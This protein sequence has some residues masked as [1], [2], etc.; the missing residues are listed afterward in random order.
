MENNAYLSSGVNIDEGNRFVSLIKQEVNST[1]TDNTISSIGGFAGLFDITSFKEMENP[2]LVSSTDGVGTKLKIAIQSGKVDTVGIDL[3][4]MSVN[5]LIVL[6]ATPLFFLDYIATGSLASEQMAE[7]VK[8]IAS[9]CR[10]CNMAL[11]GGET[12]EMPGMY[13]VGDFDLAGFAVGIVD[14]SKIIDGST[15]K[16]GDILIGIS[17]SGFHSN[18]YS[19]VRKIVSEKGLDYKSIFYG[20]VTVAEALLI[21]TNLYVNIVKSVLEKVNVKGMVHITGGG[22]YDN[23][24]RV[25][26]DGLGAEL[27]ISSVKLPKPIEKLLKNVEIS[28]HELYRVFNMGVGFVFIVAKEDREAVFKKA[29]EFNLDAYLLGSVVK[30]KNKEE[31]IKIKGID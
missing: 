29:K 19:L 6:G 14:K 16:E 27:D 8:A 26:P 31:R 9:A 20:D 15:I 24:P 13:Q 22:F 7:V 30:T 3:V 17:S 11:L 5:D 25:L 4:A 10:E 18:G 21:P 23:I 28:K 2:V 12:A 1:K